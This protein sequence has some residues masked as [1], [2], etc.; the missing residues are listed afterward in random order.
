MSTLQ[1]AHRFDALVVG[2][3]NRTAVT[4]ARAVASAP[5]SAYNPLLIYARPGM[6]KTH[7]LGAIA[8]EVF[9]M[10][11][12]ARIELLTLD[13][14]VEGFHVALSTGRSDEFRARFGD[15]DL[16]LVDDIQ[17][18]SRQR[19]MQSELLRVLDVMLAGQKQVVLTSDRAP[20]E[21]ESL[22]DRLLTRFAGGLVLDIA[23]PDYETR[24][25]ILQRKAEE[26]DARFPDGV[27]EAVASLDIESVREL[28][29]ALNRLMAFQAVSEAPIDAAQARVLIGGLRAAAAPE[30]LV[31]EQADD[32]AFAV[33][34]QGEMAHAGESR[35]VLADALPGVMLGQ[36]DM[37]GGG[38]MDELTSPQG[39]EGDAAPDD[40]GLAGQP[41]EYQDSHQ[42][43]EPRDAGESPD[44]LGDGLAE[45]P[46]LQADRD[47]FGDF[48]TDLAATLARQ[49]DPWR[50]RVGEAILRWEGEGFRTYRLE[51]LL[52]DPE[53]PDP[54]SVMIQYEA[55]AEQLLELRAEAESLSPEMAAAAQLTDPGNMAAADAFMQ[56]VREAA[57]P[58][59]GPAEHWQLDD[60]IEGPG[61]RMAVRAAL[62]AIA[63]PGHKYNPIV[64]VGGSGVGKTHLLHGIG[65]ALALASG[66]H[67]A[68]LSAHDFTQELIDAI[69]R[70]GVAAWRNRYRRCS[71]LLID[72][73]H[74][75]AGKERTQEELFLLFNLFLESNRQLGFASAVPLAELSGVEPRLLT[76][77]E[78]GLVVE[79]PP[80]DRELRQQLVERTLSSRGQDADAELMT[81]IASRPAESARAVQGYVQR[82]L[83]SADSQQVKPTV[84]LARE[85]LEGGAR[86]MRKGSAPGRSISVSAASSG[87]VKSPEKMVRTW[88]TLADRVIEEWR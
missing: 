14:F 23:Q 55:D 46:A 79:L 31:V 41:H 49:V 17:F 35:R 28:V 42:F 69:D 16:L 68:C 57:V 11:P 51:R 38:S 4:A 86:A 12:A 20:S 21:I 29:G 67:V 60:L 37:L 13:E 87:G 1:G 78:G 84:A 61:N 26:R 85:V 33:A 52:E 74:L 10:N 47:E 50:A 63:E 66:G 44:P 75:V 81:Y 8:H 40:F 3:A 76:R 30:E 19:E 62:A 25:A 32:M 34:G 27:L 15:A 2:T 53:P 71:A 73:V 83:H 59:A 82:V 48:L 39:H 9:A 6:G 77:L 56:R 54:E 22:D 7:L 58:P 65:N 36:S 43:H 24:V 80:P 64:V 72:D 5:G 88:P 45:K 70:D 18:L